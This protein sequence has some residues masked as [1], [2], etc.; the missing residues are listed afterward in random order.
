VNQDKAELVPEGDIRL[1]LF[2]GKEIRQVFHNNEW[3]FSV[4]DVIKILSGSSRPRQ[5]WLAP[6]EATR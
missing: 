4:T 5:Y 1:I 3:F 6:K 2:K